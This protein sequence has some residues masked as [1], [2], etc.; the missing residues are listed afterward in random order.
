M[1]H[2]RL[3]AAAL[4][5]QGS[6]PALHWLLR[7]DRHASTTATSHDHAITDCGAQPTPL[8]ASVH[9]EA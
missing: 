6:Q 7:A 3:T 9:Q 5:M 4:L 1:I 8:D 2:R